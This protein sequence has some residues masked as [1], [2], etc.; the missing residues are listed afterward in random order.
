M[1]KIIILPVYWCSIARIWSF[2]NAQCN[3]NFFQSSGPNCLYAN[4]HKIDRI[5]SE[6]APLL[7][8]MLPPLDPSRHLLLAGVRS[9]ISLSDV[10][11]SWKDPCLSPLSAV[12]VT[13]ILLQVFYSLWTKLRCK[14]YVNVTLLTNVDKV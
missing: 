11:S 1:Y 4:F 6:K 8:E 12:R 2:V 13:L 3:A 7:L 5:C 14:N 10:E 9:R